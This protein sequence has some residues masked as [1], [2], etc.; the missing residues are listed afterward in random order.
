MKFLSVNKQFGFEILEHELNKIIKTC[1]IS[2]K[3]ETG[4]I[5]IGYYSKYHH[6]AQVTMATLLPK[7]SEQKENY[8]IR[9]CKGLKTLLK[10]IWVTK[11]EYY[12]GEW[13]YHPYSSPSPSITDKA[14]MIEISNNKNTQCPEP[15]MLIIGGSKKQGFKLRTFVFPKNKMI[16]MK[17]RD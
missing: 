3:N 17:E 14:Q 10:N 11:E 9:G 15:V 1:V 6:C 2:D 12:L 7:D 5:L 8:L 4:G 16:E 13:H